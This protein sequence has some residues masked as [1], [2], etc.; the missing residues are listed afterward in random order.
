MPSPFM[1]TEGDPDLWMTNE[2]REELE[3]WENGLDLE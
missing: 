3:A 2:E 1:E